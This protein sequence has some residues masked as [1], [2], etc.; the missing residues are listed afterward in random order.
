MPRR[1]QFRRAVSGG[2]GDGVAPD[3]AWDFTGLASQ[4][5]FQALQGWRNTDYTYWDIATATDGLSIQTADAA[6]GE[7]RCLQS[8]QPVGAVDT[9][10]GGGFSMQFASGFDPRQEAWF[11]QWVK[12]APGWD[13]AGTGL[14]N[15]DFKA[16]FSSVGNVYADVGSDSAR[17]LISLGRDEWKAGNSGILDR[18]TCFPNGGNDLLYIAL[19]AD[20]GDLGWFRVRIHQRTGGTGQGIWN[21]QFYC[22]EYSGAPTV[23]LI[24]EGFTPNNGLYMG[25]LL[26]GNNINKPLAQAQWVRWGQPRVWF[27]NPS[28]ARTGGGTL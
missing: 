8:N 21:V 5:A 10:A 18:C 12:F 17:I 25:Q 26:F 28:W 11:E 13:S 15:P 7:E 23:Q 3:L 22:Q 24:N 1:L 14:N 2:G 9:T 20:I 6:P 16:W 19:P 27:S 4:A